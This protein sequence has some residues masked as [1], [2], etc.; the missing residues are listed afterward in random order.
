[1]TTGSLDAAS[2]SFAGRLNKALKRIGNA[3][4]SNAVFLAAAK[5]AQ[6]LSRAD[7]FCLVAND[8][9]QYWVVTLEDVQRLA[10]DR[11]SSLGSLIH[12]AGSQAGE[13][14]VQHRPGLEVELP[15]GRR[16]R[17]ETLL[18]V[19]F[20]ATATHLS[21]S[22]F[23]CDGFLPSTE[24]LS[25]LPA[26]AWTSS[27]ALRTQQREEELQHRQEQQ[28]S[29]ILELQHRARNILALVRS[30]IR[31]SSIAADST[32]YFAQ[33]LEARISALARTQGAL[34]IDD[35]AGPEL[36]DLIRAEMAA[37]AVRDNQFELTGPSVRLSIRGAET[38][39]LTLHELTTNALKFGALTTP[40]G[41]IAVTWSVD[42]S[43]TPARLRW[44][45]IESGVSLVATTTPRRGF[46]Q[47]LIE[48]VLPYE[49]DARTQFTFAPGG[50][51]CEIDLPINERTVSLSD[52]P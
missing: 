3:Q 34:S 46:G 40:E 49:L 5:A 41:H 12:S 50:L 23:W 21:L 43:T 37:N 52:A 11:A 32:E 19:P 17:T 28:R 38:M 26:L 29:Q 24:Q 20:G 39:A 45:W 22:Y 16:L 14:I 44:Q 36:E 42:A 33:H 30:I 27:L 25:L 47:E 15:T 8:A 31:R 9:S 48:R 1:M 51:L 7:G 35:R 2:L 4:G 18:T 13:A 6:E 10:I